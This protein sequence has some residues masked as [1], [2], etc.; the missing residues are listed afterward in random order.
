MNSQRRGAC[1]D[2]REEQVADVGDQI[3]RVLDGLVIN[4]NDGRTELVRRGIRK[5]CGRQALLDMLK[6]AER[7]RQTE[8]QGLLDHRA[9]SNFSHRNRIQ[10]NA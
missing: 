8:L 3:D 6:K 2:S 1:V 7:E 10:V 5:L 4:Q 9:V